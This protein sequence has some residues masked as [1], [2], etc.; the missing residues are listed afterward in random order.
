MELK[1]PIRARIRVF[2][3]DVSELTKFIESVKIELASRCRCTELS[4]ANALCSCGDVMTSIEMKGLA[5]H[6]VLS[7]KGGID[8]EL[9]IVGNDY[10]AIVDIVTDFREVA[11]KHGVGLM[12]TLD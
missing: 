4:F 8:V 10:D 11:R 1:P 7:L 12:L 3:K 9:V 6:T 2:A 5:S